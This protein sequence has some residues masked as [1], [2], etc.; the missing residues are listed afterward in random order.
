MLL[1]L[2]WVCVGGWWGAIMNFMHN[3]CNLLPVFTKCLNNLKITK[4]PQTKKG[5]ALRGKKIGFY[6]IH[7]MFHISCLLGDD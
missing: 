3:V 1:L 5:K 6:N 4:I 2:L 7:V